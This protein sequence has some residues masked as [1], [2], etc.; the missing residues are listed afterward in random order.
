MIE[1]RTGKQVSPA[2]E[3]STSGAAPFE[4]KPLSIERC[5]GPQHAKSLPRK[6]AAANQRSLGMSEERPIA[7]RPA[8]CNPAPHCSQ[9]SSQ[10]AKILGS[11][12]MRKKGFENRI[13]DTCP[14][15]SKTER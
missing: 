1:G 10:P 14:E 6:A 13:P 3:K 11:S 15:I 5:A 7:N 8:G 9:K 12:R 4:P 2:A